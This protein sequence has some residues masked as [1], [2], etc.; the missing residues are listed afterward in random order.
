[1][2]KEKTDVPHPV[3]KTRTNPPAKPPRTF[4]QDDEPKKSPKGTDQTPSV[5]LREKTEVRSSQV[6]TCTHHGNKCDFYLHLLVMHLTCSFLKVETLS[7]TTN[8][9]K[10]FE[11]IRKRADISFSVIHP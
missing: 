4:D 1:M 3:L 11:K 10:E 5:T 8:N 6:F 2:L 7:C 9:L